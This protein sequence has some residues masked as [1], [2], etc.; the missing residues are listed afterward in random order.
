MLYK[1]AFVQ[2][3]SLSGRQSLGRQTESLHIERVKQRI[4]YE[5]SKTVNTRHQNF[6]AS[7]D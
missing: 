7:H 1:S 4:F 3:V 2:V 6:G 5:W